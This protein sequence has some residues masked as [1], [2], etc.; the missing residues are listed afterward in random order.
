MHTKITL[1]GLLCLLTLA[2]RAQEQEG[3]IRYLLTHNW[4]K[5]LA[6]VEYISQQTRERETYIAGN[7][8]E[9]KEYANLYFTPTES[10]YEESE[11]RADK[12]DEGYS[13]RKEAY[14]IKHNY[15]KKTQFD[16][17]TMAGKVYIVEDS[18]YTPNWKI[19][20]D[21]KEV[22]GHLCM[23]A[24]Y[25]DTLKMQ[26]VTAWFAMDMPLPAG[27]ERMSG[28][29]GLILEADINNGALTLI[30]DRIEL[31]KLTT[32]LE[33]PKKIKGKKT[34]EAEFRAAMKKFYDER[35][36]AEQMPWGIR[37]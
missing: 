13:W 15:E 23:K 28:L 10:K 31:K 34:T 27:P 18:L 12:D 30:A 3:V 16:V 29:P 19:L 17:M 33:L 2:G 26:K 9:W 37:Y 20:N 4:A 14:F 22:Q 5:K 11:E 21:L 36:K 8:W 1:I 35:R 32:E 7:R 25:E 6:A 24:Y